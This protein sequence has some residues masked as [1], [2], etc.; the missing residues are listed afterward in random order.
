MANNENV[1]KR[2]YWLKLTDSFFK[3]KEI[4]L[5]EGMRNGEKYLIFY[6]K[7]LCESISNEGCL[8]FNKAIPYTDQMLAAITHTDIDIVVRAKQVFAEMDLIEVWA[9]DTIHMNGAEIMIGSQSESADRVRRYRERKVQAALNPASGHVST[10]QDGVEV[11]ELALHCNAD[12]ALSNVTGDADVTDKTLQC[13]LEN[14]DKRLDNRDTNIKNK[15]IYRDDVVVAEQRL[16]SQSDYDEICSKI[17]KDNCDYYID[18]VK[19]FMERVPTAVFNPKYAILKWHHEDSIK[20]GATNSV[21]VA[22]AYI[23][24]RDIERRTYSDDELQ[25]LF[26]ALDEE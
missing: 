24:G 13:N 18:R 23:Q 17:G 11:T 16:L 4:Q 20:L 2:Y 1:G 15:D 10:L 26:T 6:L 25:A 22:T 12:V 21:K 7:L 9:D 19:A 3:R 14:R 5:I 8:R